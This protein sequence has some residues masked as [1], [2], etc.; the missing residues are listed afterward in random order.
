MNENCLNISLSWYL[1]WHVITDTMSSLILF[2]VTGQ[3]STECFINIYVLPNQ[4]D[5]CSHIFFF[6]LLPDIVNV[7]NK[8]QEKNRS[9]CVSLPARP[10][11]SAA[12]SWTAPF[13]ITFFANIDRACFRCPD[14][15]EKAFLR[16]LIRRP[17]SRWT[18]DLT[19]TAPGL[20]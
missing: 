16:P 14:S 8:L 17:N 11:G 1:Y 15:V 9:K 3:A 18:H 7:Y 6:L 12:S 4:V 13:G 20:S 5:I 10:L 2:L 19:I